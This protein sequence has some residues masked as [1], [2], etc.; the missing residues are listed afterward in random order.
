M[1]LSG[2]GALGGSQPVVI[3]KEYQMKQRMA[4]SYRNVT[5]LKNYIFNGTMNVVAIYAKINFEF[6]F[7]I[8]IWK[9][10]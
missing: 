8:G 6:Y 4:K 5:V 1:D 7:E 9:P 2:R 3:T 10:V